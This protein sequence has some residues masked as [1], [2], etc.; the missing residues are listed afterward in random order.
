MLAKNNSL[1]VVLLCFYN[2]SVN[3]LEF[4]ICKWNGIRLEMIKRPNIFHFKYFKI[5]TVFLVVS[6]FTLK[7]SANF[8]KELVL[9]GTWGSGEKEFGLKKEETCIEGPSS[10]CVDDE[11]N[12]YIADAVNYRLKK[13][14]K[15]GKLLQIKL[16][17][18]EFSGIDDLD[19][20]QNKHLFLIIRTKEGRRIGISEMDLNL[21]VIRKKKLGSIIGPNVEGYSG[22]D[23]A[24][25]N[26]KNLYLSGFS[27]G[28]YKISNFDGG[29]RLDKKLRFSNGKLYKLDKS[30]EHKTI[31]NNNLGVSSVYL[32]GSSGKEK[33]Q[34]I[35]YNKGAFSG[36]DN[37]GRI[38]FIERTND[39]NL[40]LLKVYGENGQLLDS[41]FVRLNT[42]HYSEGSHYWTMGKDN[43]YYQV[44][45]DEKGF[46]IYRYRLLLNESD[47]EVDTKKK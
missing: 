45:S 23:I 9:F 43:N 29:E 38:Y 28:L 41:V 36:S 20:D 42:I 30:L 27:E 3:I 31:A 47:K 11:G 44:N 4:C 12:L 14:S 7:V 5:S 22:I 8:E 1:D 10:F 40:G 32:N 26:V 35:T 21:N 39:R 17:K 13:Y 25:D 19:V 33:V 16:Y 24:V 46:Y 15:S 6:I 34:Q 2:S 18:D 37:L